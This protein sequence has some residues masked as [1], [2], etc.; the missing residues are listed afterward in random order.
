MRKKSFRAIFVFCLT[1]MLS[2]S[3]A[4]SVFAGT[5]V[6]STVWN[7]STQ[8][9]DDIAGTSNY[10]NIYSSYL[11]TGSSLISFDFENHST[12]SLKVTLMKKNPIPLFADTEIWSTTLSNY[13]SSVISAKDVSASDKFYFKFSS[14]TGSIDVVGGVWG[15]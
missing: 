14:T 8:G 11:Y 6:P 15:R 12:Y 1:I 7:L 5:A 2:V 3:T 4:G 13:M 9:K 10:V